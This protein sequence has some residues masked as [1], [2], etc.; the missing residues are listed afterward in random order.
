V[1]L[2]VGIRSTGTPMGP[3]EEEGGESPADADA[4]GAGC[5]LAGAPLAAAPEELEAL[6]LVREAEQSAL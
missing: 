6:H 5:G 1:G 2:D 4:A 3:G